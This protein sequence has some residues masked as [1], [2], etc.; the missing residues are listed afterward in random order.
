[1][2]FTL[3]PWIETCRVHYHQWKA[4]ADGKE[5]SFLMEGEYY[6]QVEIDISLERYVKLNV[7]PILNS[8]R[9]SVLHD[10]TKVCQ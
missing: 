1:M 4:G 5:K 10:M 6:Q 8:R 7:P 9:A 3:Q 2:S